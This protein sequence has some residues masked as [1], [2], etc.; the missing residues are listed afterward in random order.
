MLSHAISSLTPLTCQQLRGAFLCCG[1]RFK[2]KKTYIV[3]FFLNISKPPLVGVLLIASKTFGEESS[4]G[5]QQKRRRRFFFRPKAFCMLPD[6]E[7][8]PFGLFSCGAERNNELV[9]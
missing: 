3:K 8:I 7:M 9:T 1:G 5:E 4:L 6:Q 2:T